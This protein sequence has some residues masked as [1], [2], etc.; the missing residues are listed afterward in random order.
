M[1]PSLF[2]IEQSTT[3]TPPKAQW[4]SHKHD[5]LWIGAGVELMNILQHLPAELSRRSV[6][7]VVVDSIAML[8]R[9]EF[10]QD[11]IPRRQR[12]LA[13]QAAL[14]KQSAEQF[15]LTVV[16]TN[17]IMGGQGSDGQRAAL[18]V[19]W[20]HAVNTR[21]IMEQRHGIRSIRVLHLVCHARLLGDA[22]LR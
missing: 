19:V 10:S 11:D 17:Q 4:Y 5:D 8:A 6:G 13:Q 22:Q 9:L 18:G 14:L 15:N 20:G 16:V 2:L 7:L 12:F 3:Y 1:P 21:L